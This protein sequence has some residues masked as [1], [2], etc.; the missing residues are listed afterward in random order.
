MK[1]N[2]FIDKVLS[3]EKIVKRLPPLCN[4]PICPSV[5]GD[6]LCE[7]CGVGIDNNCWHP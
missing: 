7:Y 5:D 6:D 4:D 1:R 2:K 3:N